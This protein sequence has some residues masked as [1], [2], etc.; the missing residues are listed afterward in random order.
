MRSPFYTPDDS[1]EVDVE[2]DGDCARLIIRAKASRLEIALRVEWPVFEGVLAKSLRFIDPV[3]RVEIERQAEAERRLAEREALLAELRVEG[4]KYLFELNGLR[5]SGVSAS[6]SWDE[7]ADRHG[8]NVDRVQ[9]A[10]RLHQ[11]AMRL[12]RDTQIVELV[13]KGLSNAAVAREAGVTPAIVSGVLRKAR[14]D[15]RVIGTRV[16]PP[17]AEPDTE[18]DDDV[19]AAVGGR[20]V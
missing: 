19:A 13:N 4:R 7:V 3:R 16:V 12:A 9:V 17:P 18:A 5:N 15:G 20:D 11:R 2:P 14:S 8:V 6:D 10:V 1:F